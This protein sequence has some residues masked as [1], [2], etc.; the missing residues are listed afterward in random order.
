MELYCYQCDL[1]P[2]LYSYWLLVAYL[3]PAQERNSRTRF[4]CFISSGFMID[5]IIMTL[6]SDIIE[7]K[8]NLSK[9]VL[10]FKIKDDKMYLHQGSLQD[11]S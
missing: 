11:Y 9:N 3:K 8:Q 4:W 10:V 7:Q 5:E 2:G 6:F 1:M